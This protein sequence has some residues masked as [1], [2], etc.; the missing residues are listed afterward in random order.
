MLVPLTS[1]LYVPGKILE[2]TRVMVD[3]GTG[4]V[5]EMSSTAAQESMKRKY[6][7][8]RVSYMCSHIALLFAVTLL[9]HIYGVNRASLFLRQRT[10]TGKLAGWIISNCLHV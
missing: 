6:N 8:L 9:A 10:D 3:I 1:S 2:P 5:V 7:M 4:Y